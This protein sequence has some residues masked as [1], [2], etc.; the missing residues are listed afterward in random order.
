MMLKTNV[1]KICAMTLGASVL[2]MS[3]CKE[4]EPPVPPKLSFA[5]SE[6][7]VSENAGV[8]EV[9]LVLDRAYGDD[10][11][12]EYRLSGTASDQDAVGSANADYEVQGT[13]ELVV[14]E[15][16]QTSAV[17]EIEIYNDAV[18]E[19]DETIEISIIDVNTSDVEV[20]ADDEIEIT[21]TNDDAALELAFAAQEV[22]VNEADQV[23]EVEVTLSEPAPE[24]LVITYELGGTA[25][26]SITAFY[27]ELNPDYYVHGEAGELI[28]PQGET[29]GIVELRFYTDLLV[30]D[31]NPNTEPI[32]PETIT[33][34]A[35]PPNGV[36]MDDNEMTISL[37]Q[38][39]GLLIAL[40]WPDPA[41]EQQA[42]MDILLRVG[43]TESEWL[44]FLTGSTAG[45]FEG[46]EIIFV[47]YALQFQYYGL[48]YPYFEGTLDP[49]EFEA[50]F[51]DL[52]DGALEAA[53]DT[54][55]YTATYTA[56]NINAWEQ[57]SSTIVVQTFEKT[58]TGFST[59]TEITVPT[60][61]SRVRPGDHLPSKIRK[62]DSGTFR[63]GTRLL[64]MYQ[65]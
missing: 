33:I 58:E 16:G 13:H 45:S 40:F 61:G 11:N 29:T 56:A 34:T 60:S 49:L 47:P 53:A 27:D 35:T 28:I 19:P 1:L 25:V 5:E 65:R 10:L 3:S 57:P 31:A 46:P 44:G 7:T 14:I 63:P 2:V 21:I 55:S 64:E 8:I 23:L 38:E 32:E 6:M 9:E 59:P 54:E 17:I 39:D 12:V 15:S 62:G 4:D 36:T 51:I 41:G 26:D 18:F 52:V 43:D 50:V 20:T 37:E 48:S 22:S 30:E 24:D 42:D